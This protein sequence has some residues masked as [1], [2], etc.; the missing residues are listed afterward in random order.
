[1]IGKM[2][3]SIL[4]LVSIVILPACN[5]PG[6]NDR[7]SST[8]LTES[9]TA[10]APSATT[11]DK[12]LA[13]LA[14]SAAE[15]GSFTTLTRAVEA[16]GLKEN[17][18]KGE[19]Y[20]VFAPTDA[21]FE[22]LPAGTVEKLMQP[23]NKVKLSKLLAYHVVPG[24]V[25][26][27]KLPSGQVKTVEGTPVNITVDSTSSTVMI[28]EARIIQPDIPASNGVIHVVDRVILPPD[29]QISLKPN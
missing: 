24:E 19:P 18:A 25:T 7:T 14:Q 4:G 10:D 9:P 26:S 1:M 2:L 11:E 12:N 15:N 27:N 5:L 16:A 6:A 3:S 21:A 28:N 23:E 8:S 20:T 13:E 17:L 22:E 29:L